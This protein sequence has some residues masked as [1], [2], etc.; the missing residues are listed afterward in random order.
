MKQHHILTL[1]SKVGIHLLHLN[2]EEQTWHEYE[3]N[4]VSAEH[5]HKL[6]EKHP[7]EV[8]ALQATDGTAVPLVSCRFIKEIRPA[9]IPIIL[10]SNPAEASKIRL[11]NY[12]KRISRSRMVR[13]FPWY[14]DAYWNCFVGGDTEFCPEEIGDVQQAKSLEF[15]NGA[16][17]RSDSE[18]AG[19]YLSTEREICYHYS[20]T[21][22]DGPVIFEF[23]PELYELK[24]EHACILNIIT[25]RRQRLL[26]LPVRTTA[27]QL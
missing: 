1:G 6:M 11:E 24:L 17:F 21:T 12:R 27:K 22:E 19:H 16:A 8:F 14:E 4:Y 15:P 2:K 23:E 3:G 18:Y 5:L 26:R 13:D 9:Y 10:D 20:E 25:G 7:D